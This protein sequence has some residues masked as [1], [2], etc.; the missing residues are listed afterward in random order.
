M[1]ENLRELAEIANYAVFSAGSR[2]NRFMTMCFTCLDLNT[3]E[4]G[5]VSAGHTPPYIFNKTE[6]RVSTIPCSGSLLGFSENPQFDFESC[7]LAAGDSVFLYT[8][9]LL[10]NTTQSGPILNARNLRKYLTQD[11]PPEKC[12]EHLSAIVNNASKEQPL[13]DDVTVYMFRWNGVAESKL[14]KAG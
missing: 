5:V 9:G 3:G 1:R 4:L 7:T 12:V 8:D 13:D 2:S 10:E 14:Q 6:K 11:E